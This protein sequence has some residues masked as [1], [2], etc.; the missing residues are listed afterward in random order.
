VPTWITGTVIRGSIG[1]S[2]VSSAS[3]TG[4]KSSIQKKGDQATLFADT[5]EDQQTLTGP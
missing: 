4:P 2:R 5:A 3:T 1:P